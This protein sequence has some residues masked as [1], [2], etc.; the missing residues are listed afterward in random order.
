M[1]FQLLAPVGV[2]PC[3]PEHGMLWKQRKLWSIKG[4]VIIQGYNYSF[5]LTGG[6]KMKGGSAQERNKKDS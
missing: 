4:N 3:Q 2:L 1:P 5:G 6:V